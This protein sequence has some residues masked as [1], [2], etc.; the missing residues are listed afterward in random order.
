VSEGHVHANG[1]TGTKTLIGGP[2]DELLEGGNDDDVIDG[3]EGNDQLDDGGGEFEIADGG[4]NDL[5]VGG[6]GEDFAPYF[7]GDVAVT[8][9]L[10]GLANDG[11]AGEADN[12]QVENVSSGEGNDILVG[13]GSPNELTGG[14]GGD[15]V[16]GLA[17]NDDLIGDGFTGAMLA[18][19]GPP[20]IGGDDT[21][22]GGAGRD[23]LDCGPGFDLALR[24]PGDDVDGSCERIGAEVV[25]DSAAV[26]KK[27]KFKVQMECSAAE[28]KACSGK[29]K[30]TSAGKK[31][32]KGKF[33][34]A[35]GKTKGGK[36]KLSKKGAKK[37]RKGGGSLLVTV[38]AKT[39]EPGGVSEDRETVFLH[40]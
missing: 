37:L 36:A 17:G 6:P 38:I 22:D 21:L 19:G 28:V 14:D 18:R 5:L 20:I 12:V 7:R 15:L 9:T 33:S 27:N 40:R 4:G 31:A 30:I 2:G 11:Q 35:A 16:R 25:G 34:V 26:S 39:D 23:G 29:L 8:I 1:T 24:A 3:G 13:D 10:D 32:G